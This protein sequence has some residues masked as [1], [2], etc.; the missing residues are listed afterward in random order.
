[1]NCQRSVREKN[2]LARELFWC[3][4]T[5]FVH[6]AQKRK[7]KDR[8]TDSRQ[9][10]K[11]NELCCD[12]W[13]AGLKWHSTHLPFVSLSLSLS[14]VPSLGFLQMSERTWGSQQWAFSRHRPKFASGVWAHHLKIAPTVASLS[15]PPI[16]SKSICGYTQVSS[17]VFPIPQAQ[18]TSLHQ[19][20]IYCTSC[21]I[22]LASCSD[23]SFGG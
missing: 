20:N 19:L 11:K 15:A 17:S 6:R 23:I 8:Q 7:D 14:P 10:G 18:I 9:R 5:A 22:Y 1:M 3:V 2:S 21:K 4:C 16:I 13:R 12:V